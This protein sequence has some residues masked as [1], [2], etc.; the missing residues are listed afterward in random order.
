VL[1][2]LLLSLLA[3]LLVVVGGIGLRYRRR[4]VG[5]ELRRELLRRLDRRPS[6]SGA[7]VDELRRSGAV[8]GSRV[9]DV[10]RQLELEGA[11]RGHWEND[12]DGR[13]RRV[14]AL[15]CRASFPEYPMD[16]GASC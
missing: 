7:L 10:L 1:A 4:E 8:R 3:V 13:P 15:A 14:Y 2:T 9:C 5:S 12:G 11:I 6:H 16:T